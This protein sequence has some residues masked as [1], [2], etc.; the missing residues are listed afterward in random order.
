MVGTTW[1]VG[2]QKRNFFFK[3]KKLKLK[4]PSSQAA[5]LSA[6]FMVGKKCLEAHT[7]R[8]WSR[9]RCAWDGVQVRF[10]FWREKGAAVSLGD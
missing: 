9:W 6:D 10:R 2:K 1:I 8:D 7:L 4:M 5:R 3:I